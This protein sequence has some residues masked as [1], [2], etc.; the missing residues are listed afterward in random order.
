MKRRGGPD[1]QEAL[2]VDEAIRHK[3]QKGTSKPGHEVQKG[4]T[5]Y[6]HPARRPLGAAVDIPEDHGAKQLELEIPCDSGYCMT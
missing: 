5:L 2:E 3:R 4:I 6:V 1:W